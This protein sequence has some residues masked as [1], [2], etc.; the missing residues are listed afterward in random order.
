M[1]QPPITIAP[2]K[3]GW[4]TDLEPWIAPP[5]SFSV[6]DNFHIHHGYV[7]KR[8]GYRRFGIFTHNPC[9][10]ISGITAPGVSPTVITSPDT[11]GL[12]NGNI[13]AFTQVAGMTEINN[14]TGT[15]SALTG[16]T[17]EIDIDTTGFTAYSAGGVVCIVPVTGKRIMGIDR[18]VSPD[19]SQ[20]T[21]VWD[22]TRAARFNAALDAFI[23]LDTAAIMGCGEEDYIWT[24][25]WQHSGSTN[26][27]Y[28]TNGLEYDGASLNGIRYYD[29]GTSTSA[30]T[31]FTPDLNTGAT[32]K[33]YGGKLIFA[34]K[35]RLVVLNTFE[36]DGAI[37]TNYPQRARWCQAQG[38]SNW[39]DLTPGGGGFVDAP[40]GEQ[41]I[42][43]R[44]L[45]DAIIVFFT[46]SVWT[47]RPVPDPAL[48]FRWDRINDFRA[49]NG[50]MAT[51]GYDRYVAAIG[52]RGITITD[53]VETRRIDDRIEDF[54]NDQVNFD[55][56]GKVFCQRSF[57]ERRMWSL[58]PSGFSDSDET[59]SALIYDDESS[60]FSKYKIAMNCLGI[61]ASGVDFGLDDFVA[62]KD[63]DL[64]IEE[65]GEETLQDFY[66]QQDEETLLGGDINGLV[67]VMETGTSDDG[68]DID[69]SLITAA[70]NPFKE[71]GI[72]CQMNYID[73]F[74]DTDADTKAIIYFFKDNDNAP[75]AQ[76]HLDLLPNLNYVS[77]INDVS[78]TNPAAIETPNHGLTTG[79]EIY[80]Y[81]V[82]GTVSI[83]KKQ[84]T[85]TVVDSN[86]ITLD[87]IDATGY[88]PYL[89]GGQIVER[90][91]YRTKTWKRAY[92]GG[93]GYQHRIQLDTEGVSKP[94]RIHAF[95]PKFKPIKGR[96]TN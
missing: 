39:D 72:E 71:Q 77:D 32:R 79:D 31:L 42:S 69:S 49:C 33:L 84:Y 6:I 58:Y 91:F 74:F 54:V 14:Q 67:Y 56:F 60:A 90:E 87:G 51:V 83:N 30:T 12:S 8:S 9:I 27:L 15:V 66:W 34:I 94:M 36:L 78:L 85:V 2:F 53:G 82:E 13:V 43:A 18:Y 88:N 38:P 10:T 89:N 63:L 44:P 55:D 70:W 86:N 25:N 5:D 47:L 76:Q 11:T 4:D 17:F 93:I 73:I 50:K 80:I 95:K 61:G 19:G 22:T 20:D 35:Q 81:G 23:P 92:A 75:Y 16:T 62:S 40:T 28:F 96:T 41:I 29:S 59:D 26:R 57:S 48:P 24:E 21:L 37:V 65:F 46:D 68:A 1:S 52:V 3:T 64:T 7:E 45:Q